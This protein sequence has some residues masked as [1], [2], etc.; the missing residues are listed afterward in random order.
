LHRIAPS[1]TTADDRP[2][3][4]VHDSGPGLPDEVRAHLFTPFFSTKKNGRG[5]GLTLAHEIL[6]QHGC[7]FALDNHPQGGAEFTIR[8]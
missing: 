5:L 1:L 7:E 2:T 3:L 4:T 8:F 6:T